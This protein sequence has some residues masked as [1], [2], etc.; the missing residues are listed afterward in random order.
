[1]VPESVPLTANSFGFPNNGVLSL[2]LVFFHL[3]PVR[4]LALAF[5]RSCLACNA[6]ASNTSAVNSTFSSEAGSTLVPG[7]GNPLASVVL[8]PPRVGQRVLIVAPYPC[9]SGLLLLSRHAG[10][11]FGSNLEVLPLS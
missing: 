2:V 6:M 7:G 9:P 4:A 10:E 1:M 3:P 8:D 11:K 5:F